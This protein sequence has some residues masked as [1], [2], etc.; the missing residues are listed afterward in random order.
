MASPHIAGIAATCTISGA[1]P[2]AS[3]C[4]EKL[5]VLQAAAKEKLVASPAYNAKSLTDGV[6]YY[7]QLAWAKF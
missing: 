3:T 2:A 5:A 1:C 7:G 4:L 6:K